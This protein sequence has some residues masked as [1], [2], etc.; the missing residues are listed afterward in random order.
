MNITVLMENTAPCHL[1][2]EHGLSFHIQH[3]GHSILLDAGSSGKFADNAQKLG[4]DLAGVEWAALSHGHY[5][6]ADGFRRF[7]AENQ[8]APVYLRPAA[9]KSWFS[10]SQ[11]A[12]RFIGIHRDMFP[13]PRFVVLDGLFSPMEGAWLVPET[14]RGGPF[15]NREKTLLEKIGP[16]QFV[17]DDFSHEQ[18]LV[19]ESERGLVLFNSCSHGGIVNIVQ[20]VLEQFGGKQVYAVLGGLHLIDPEEAYVNA[21]ADRLAELGVERLYTGHC[22]SAA[23]FALLRERLQGRLYALTTGARIEL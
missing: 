8:T 4:V 11:G 7:F 6:H 23:A 9:G 14:V 15:A 3:R 19:L 17:P 2:A 16:D 13:N 1:T 10:T 21:V 12:P 18:S 5:D 22:T 20:G